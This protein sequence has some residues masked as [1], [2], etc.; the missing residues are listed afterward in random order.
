MQ[1]VGFGSCQGIVSPPWPQCRCRPMSASRPTPQLCTSLPKSMPQFE[2]RAGTDVHTFGWERNSQTDRH[3]TDAENTK[4]KTKK[5]RHI[6][7][8]NCS[9]NHHPYK[10]YNLYALHCVTLWHTVSHCITLCY[11]V[12]QGTPSIITIMHCSRGCGSPWL[13]GGKPMISPIPKKKKIQN[14]KEK[15]SK[16]IKEKI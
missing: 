16:K 11:T 3:K 7:S 1:K 10:K 8:L 4:Y 2:R 9:T 15:N 13:H 12:C 6:L 14:N 5:S